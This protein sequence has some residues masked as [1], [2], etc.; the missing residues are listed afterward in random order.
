MP[1]VTY[2]FIFSSNKEV[3]FTVDLDRPALFS[4]NPKDPDVEWTNLDFNKCANCPLNSAEIKKCPTALDV[5]HAMLEFHDVLSTEIVKTY[6][7]TENR[8]YFK[9]C[10]AQTGLKA[11]VGLIMATSGCPILKEMKG[12]AYFHLPFA[13]IEE[14]IFRSVTTYL[15]KQY[16]KF[17]EKQ[18]PDWSLQ[19]IPAYFDTIQ[20]VNESFFQRIKV[21]SKADA[22]LNVIVSLSSQSQLISLSIDEYLESL[23]E[24]IVGK[25]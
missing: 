15:L 11:L 24:L 19:N 22:N 25:K 14:T 20:L 13:T 12:M 6:V 7:E 10:D 18:E 21:A 2:K 1:N 16:Y 8:S 5:Q 23:K 3:K 17:M 9:E 4:T